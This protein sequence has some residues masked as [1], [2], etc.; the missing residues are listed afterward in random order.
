ME[1]FEIRYFIAAA[2]SENLQE[3]ARELSISA[4]AISRAISR[5]EEELDVQLFNRVGR[6]IEL[7]P[8]GLAFQKEANRIIG[9]V[10]DVQLQFRPSKKAIPISISGTEFGISAFLSDVIQNLKSHKIEFILDVK[11]L[12]NTKEVEASVAEGRVR[13]G[14]ISGKTYSSDLTGLFLGKLE[15]R[16]LVGPGHPLFK[17]AKAK[18]TL[19]IEDVLEHQ[20][21]SFPQSI[22]GGSLAYQ[23]SGDGWRDDKFPRKIGLKTESIEV[24]LRMIKSGQYLGYLPSSLASEDI[25]SLSVTGCP[26]SSKTDSY[27]LAQNPKELGWMGKLFEDKGR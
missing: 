20:F 11:T 10:E 14:I 15:S 24:A 23:G 1:M 27:L 13:L 25:L 26:Y 7:S 2:N 22:Y 16:T 6:N 3:A 12:R 18:R 17:E 21:V 4:P 19:T 8:E 9:F 5:L